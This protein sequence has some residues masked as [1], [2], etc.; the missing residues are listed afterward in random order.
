M[1]KNQEKSILVGGTA[2]DDQP[3]VHVDPVEYVARTGG[4]DEED[5]AD[6]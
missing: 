4:F 3:P 5:D 1:S 2:G 6:S